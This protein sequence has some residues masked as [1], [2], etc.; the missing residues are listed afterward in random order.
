[1]TLSKK[2]HDQLLA[3]S[4]V[5]DQLFPITTAPNVG[6]SIRNYH[7]KEDQRMYEDLVIGGMSCDQAKEAMLLMGIADRDMELFNH[8]AELMQTFAW[9]K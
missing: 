5:V 8:I 9:N 4:L 3:Q 6:S 2:T 7:R 1:M